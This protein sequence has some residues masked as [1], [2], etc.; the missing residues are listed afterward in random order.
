MLLNITEHIKTIVIE[1]TNHTKFVLKLNTGYDSPH[2]YFVCVTVRDN[3]TAT[4]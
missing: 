1:I 4:D 2:L 3:L